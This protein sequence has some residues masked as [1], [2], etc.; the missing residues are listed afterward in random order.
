MKRIVIAGGTGFLGQFLAGK[1]RVNG[2]KVVIISRKHGDVHWNDVDEVIRALNGADLLINLAG[3]SVDCRYNEANKKEILKSRVDT[4]GILGEAI[5]KCQQPPKLWINS[6]TATIY[7]HAE[8]RPM[9]E[10]QG[11]IGSGFSVDVATQWVQA[12][13]NFQLQHTRQVAL[14]MAIV[15]GK[16]GG[17]IKPLKKLVRFGLGGKQGKGNQMFSWIHIDDIYQIILFIINHQGLEG[18]FNCSA[19]HPVTNEMMMRSLRKAMHVS[20]GL[21][22][23]EWLLKIGAVLIH[24]ETELI[25]KSR[26][27]LPQRLLES[28]YVFSYPSLQPALKEICES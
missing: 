2:D 1:F 12:F 15:L 20:A 8:D 27:V 9:T 18:V 21:P 7:R 6:S 17:A 13:F 4:T 19:P 11:E 25:L 16:H 3:K 5:L 22:A 26:W 28:G 10:S 24:T 23:P 14:R